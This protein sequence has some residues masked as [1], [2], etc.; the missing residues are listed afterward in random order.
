MLFYKIINKYIFMVLA[1][2][3]YRD[4][5]HLVNETSRAIANAA[6]AAARASARTRAFGI[7]LS[8]AKSRKELASI[9]SELLGSSRRDAA[10][11]PSSAGTSSG[12]P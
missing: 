7:N 5:L 11:Q 10:M 8:L 1:I 9:K 6:S 4:S 12:P 3:I 2:L